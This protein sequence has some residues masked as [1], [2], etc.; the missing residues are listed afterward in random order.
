MDIF[1]CGLIPSARHQGLSPLELQFQEGPEGDPGWPQKGDDL[2]R[3][4]MRLV[5]GWDPGFILLFVP[6]VAFRG[7]Q[8]AALFYVESP[9]AAP[10]P[11]L[12]M[13]QTGFFDHLR[14]LP[15]LA[16]KGACIFF[17]FNQCVCVF[18]KYE[19]MYLGIKCNTQLE[20]TVLSIMTLFSP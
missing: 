10:E 1:S 17:F 20:T 6:R 14:T 15:V 9:S 3:S 13:S 2:G 7:N 11:H 12:L 16:V 19:N 18:F 8:C 4:Q 5:Q